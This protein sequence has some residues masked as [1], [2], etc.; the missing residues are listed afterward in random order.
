[1]NSSPDTP[2]SIRSVMIASGICAST[3]RKASVAFVHTVSV[4][5]SSLSL[6]RKI[7][8]KK[9]SSSTSSNETFFKLFGF[10][11]AVILT[12]LLVQGFRLVLVLIL[13]QV[14]RVQVLPPPQYSHPSVV[15]FLAPAQLELLAQLVLVHYF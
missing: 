10:F 6:V 9:S 1:M 3:E 11:R 2:G 15:D 8:A 14:L 7:S 5:P 13:L 12:R 4:P